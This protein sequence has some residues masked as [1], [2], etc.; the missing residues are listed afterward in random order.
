MIFF[1]ISLTFVIF[2]PT[3][4]Y[5]LGPLKRMFLT[6]LQLLI[7]KSMSNT[8]GEVQVFIC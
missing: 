6:G 1:S 3:Q 7:S 2:I 4:I 8:K 5:S